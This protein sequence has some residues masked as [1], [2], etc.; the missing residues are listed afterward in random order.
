MIFNNVA[1][2]RRSQAEDMT[3]S[4]QAARGCPFQPS[5]TDELD[6][7]ADDPI[8]VMMQL[9]RDHGSWADLQTANRRVIFAFAPEHVQQVLTR[10]EDFHA[11]SVLYPGPR[12]S[13]QRR[14]AMSL[15]SANGEDYK[16]RRRVLQ[17]P[18]KIAAMARFQPVIQE[19]AESMLAQWRVGQEYDMHQ[20]LSRLMLRITSG[21]LF[22][23]DA[24]DAACQA[25]EM[26]HEF[27]RR[28]NEVGRPGIQ[29]RDAS[30]QCYERLLQFADKLERRILD[31]ADQRTA[32]VGHA[33]PG[34][35]VLTALLQSAGGREGLNEGK[36][37]GDLAFFFGAAHLTTAAAMSWTLL[38]LDQHPD[39]A[40]Q[41]QAEVHKVLGQQAPETDDLNRMPVMDLVIKES[42]RLLPPVCCFT[43][44]NPEETEVCGRRIPAGS[45]VMLSQYVTHR[46]PN[47]FPNP[48][49]FDP[50][51]WRERKPSAYEYFPFSAGQRM[52]LGASLATMVIKT[53]LPMMLQ[54]FRPACV[55]GARI[56]RTVSLVLEPRDG[57]PMVLRNT[58]SVQPPARI[59]GNIVEMLDLPG[60]S[61]VRRAA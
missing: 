11:Q 24:E 2:Q 51:R 57:I 5:F 32:S 48:Q 61:A 56:D 42:M 27:L 40:A 33:S 8:A 39:V 44:R 18:L 26:L 23:L 45:L 41:V 50:Q 60:Q 54:R 13:A 20:E 14:L 7:F 55:S 1:R 22:G 37:V 28:D 59:D 58:R 15:V 35:D 12:K 10:S 49:R 9:Y 19:M 25:G 53:V 31:L 30:P 21:A 38:L 43:R 46:L 34:D 4:T 47:I 52:C 29:R 3:S 6:G 17:Q 16:Q 36:R